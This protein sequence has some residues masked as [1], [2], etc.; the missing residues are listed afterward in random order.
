MTK[1]KAS[2][3]ITKSV[4]VEFDKIAKEKAVNKSGLVEILLC[5]WIKQQKKKQ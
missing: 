2:Y 1:I 4:L 3:N 5:D